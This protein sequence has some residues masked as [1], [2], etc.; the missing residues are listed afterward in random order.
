[1]SE[2]KYIIDKDALTGIADAVRDKLGTGE[3]TTDETTGEIVYP[4]DKGYYL[5]SHDCI[6]VSNFQHLFNNGT[7]SKYI[8]RFYKSDYSEKVEKF[9]SQIEVEGYV[10]WYSVT[11]TLKINGNSFS[12]ENSSTTPQKITQIF[13]S[14]QSYLSVEFSIY[15]KYSRPQ[16]FYF[17]DIKIVL[18]DENGVPI[19]LVSSGFPVNYGSPSTTCTRESIQEVTPIPFSID[20]MQDKITNYLSKGDSPF[21]YPI[22]TQMLKSGSNV[23]YLNLES[24]F[25]SVE[26]FKNRFLQAS[27][28]SGTNNGVAYLICGKNGK[29]ASMKELGIALSSDIQSYTGSWNMTDVQTSYENNLTFPLVN[30]NSNSP[31]R[32]TYWLYVTSDIKTMVL[33]LSNLI[34]WPTSNGGYMYM[35]YKEA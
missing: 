24:T 9:F 13:D 7:Y 18:K 12:L 4:E 28:N 16:Y 1:M 14:P 30:L 35:A 27:F 21:E 23:W 3:A 33:C 29:P 26:D 19:K 2:N 8:V 5:K 10:Y 6:A 25:S 17:K 22:P 32:E 20:D 31:D 34:G 15:N 11:P